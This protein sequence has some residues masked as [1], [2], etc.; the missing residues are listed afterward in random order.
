MS[1][2]TLSEMIFALSK[3]AFRY[4]YHPQ[5]PHDAGAS[6]R[7]PTEKHLQILDQLALLL[8]TEAKGDIAAIS[9]RDVEN[10]QIS[11]GYS[12]N[13]PF[14]DPETSYITDLLSMATDPTTTPTQKHGNLFCL[15]IQECRKKI[16]SRL[17]DIC[18]G[19]RRLREKKDFGIQGLESDQ[20]DE[21]ES[22]ATRTRCDHY[23]RQ[24]L[25][26]EIFP[27]TFSLSL[28]LKQWFESLLSAIPCG[29]QFQYWEHKPLVYR[30]IVIA[31]WIAG[32][33]EAHKLLDSSLLL[34]IGKLG[35]YCGAITALVDKIILL[36]QNAYGGISMVEVC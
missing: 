6:G 27:L 14:T 3:I 29:S 1:S 19:L 25:G 30:S 11:L 31:Y 7:H 24:V 32:D 28:F 35:D 36:D 9:L 13:R 17:R 26:E 2:L 16:T 33:L 21:T 15:V 4:E 12:K 23:I 10:N 20:E 18:Q 22:H 34:P 8:V 5:S